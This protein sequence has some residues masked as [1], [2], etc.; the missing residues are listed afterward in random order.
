M[1]RGTWTVR[2][3]VSFAAK[4]QAG[5][6]SSCATLSTM[7]F[8]IVL[9]LGI[10]TPPAIAAVYQDSIHRQGIAID[11]TID[12]V[13]GAD[14]IDSTTLHEGDKVIV[15]FRLSDA[16]SAKSYRGANPAA[17]MDWTGG[18]SRE[19]ECTDRATRYL[20]GSLFDQPDL[21]LNVFYVLALNA[22]PT[23]T[24]VDPL[25]GFG[26]TKLLALVVL[27]SPGEDW[28]IDDDDQYLYVSLP[29][30][31][32]VAVIDTDSW[33]VHQSLGV[34]ARPR[35]IA[36]QPDGAYLWV[37][38][39]ENTPKTSG[40]DVIRVADGT[41][42]AHIATGAGT[43]DLAFTPDNEFAFVTNR[44]ADTVSVIDIRTLLEVEEL[45]TGS[46]PVSIGYSSLA[47]AAYVAHYGDGTIAVIDGQR[48]A[49][50]QPS[51]RA[52]PGLAQIRITPDGH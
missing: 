6:V 38:S 40:V 19:R 18:S 28:A 12:P 11:V 2:R 41:V 15:R 42:L 52:E 14:S 3:T 51:P 23:I 45:A 1:I 24:V 36:F 5:Q 9:L 31:D 47:Q 46:Q 49:I 7:K 21:D 10:V 25:F 8:I 39:W 16:K 22:D 26:G 48:H 30:S 32:A 35:R 50:L 33:R 13:S 43:H 29:D 34:G 4:I 17:W 27:D 44:D 37:A 20:S